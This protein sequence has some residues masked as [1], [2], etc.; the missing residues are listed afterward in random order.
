MKTEKNYLE[1]SV[2]NEVPR[3]TNTKRN[4]ARAS[5]TEKANSIGHI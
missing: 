3:K 4:P 1:A 2:T 5:K